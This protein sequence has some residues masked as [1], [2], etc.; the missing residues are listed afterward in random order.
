MKFGVFL[1]SALVTIEK[2]EVLLDQIHEVDKTVFVDW[3]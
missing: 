2:L 1:L 3:Q